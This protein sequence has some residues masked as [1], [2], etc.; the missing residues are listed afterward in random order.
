MSD[1]II[2]T[3]EIVQKQGFSMEEYEMIKKRLGREPNYTELGMFSAM[4]SEHCSYK[5]DRKSVV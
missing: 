1:D 3:K 4:W 5:K 2:I